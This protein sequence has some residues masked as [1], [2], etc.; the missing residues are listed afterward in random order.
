M[1]ESPSAQNGYETSPENK[2]Q[3]KY[4]KSKK[5]HKSN[6]KLQKLAYVRDGYKFKNSQIT[7]RVAC[8]QANGKDSMRK[9]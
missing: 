2:K 7:R 8:L 3:K 6:R 1:E 9:Y 4:I 5:K